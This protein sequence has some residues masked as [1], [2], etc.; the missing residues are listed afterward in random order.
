M[1]G[2]GGN[3]PVANFT[4]NITSG[5]PPLTVTFTDQSTNGPASWQ[6]DFGDGNTSSQ[7]NLTHTY[8]NNGTFT[9]KLVVTNNYGSDTEIKTDY[10]VVEYV[11]LWTVFNTSNSNIPSNDVSSVAIEGSSVWIG[12][13]D[14]FIA[15]YNGSSFSHYSGGSRY[16]QQILV[17]SDNVKWIGTNG[18][19]LYKYSGTWNHVFDNGHS[20]FELAVDSYN[21]IWGTLGSIYKGIFKY[22]GA[23]LTRWNSNNSPISNTPISIAV[24]IDNSIWVGTYDGLLKFDGETWEVYTTSNSGL[25]DDRI[26]SIAIDSYGNKWIGTN[27]ELVKY[28]GSSWTIFSTDNSD[29]PGFDISSVAVDDLNNIWITTRYSTN[30]MNGVLSKF[31]GQIW[32]SFN[33]SNA[34]Y[35]DFYLKE[36]T[37]DNFGNK[38]MG[39]GNGLVKFSGN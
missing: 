8:N 25:Q 5:T 24:D 11:N 33:V 17:D 30:G 38:W 13:G 4:A 35:G 26:E 37:I 1:F 39:S 22:D 28:D 14:S 7:Q 2:G 27:T 18:D 6:W 10:I 19:G 32:T 12:L 21:N 29:I 20:V 31:D 9:V 23:T 16:V 15:K 34:G 36:I 3:P